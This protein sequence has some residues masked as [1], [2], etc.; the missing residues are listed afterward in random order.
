M[1]FVLPAVPGLPVA[2]L[3]RW[4]APVALQYRRLRAA[5]RH[6]RHPFTYAIDVRDVI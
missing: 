1:T 4:S 6:W 5:A 3:R 2:T